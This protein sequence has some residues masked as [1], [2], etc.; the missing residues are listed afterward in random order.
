MT[1]RSQHGSGDMQVPGVFPFRR[2]AVLTGEL[3]SPVTGA[4]GETGLRVTGSRRWTPISEVC[5]EA[6]CA[7][8]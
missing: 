8:L 6:C 7:T 4:A 3:C 2:L 1:A 5:W